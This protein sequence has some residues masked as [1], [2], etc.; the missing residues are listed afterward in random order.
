MKIQSITNYAN[1]ANYQNLKQQNSSKVSQS[2]VFKDYA[3]VYSKGIS[4]LYFGS[5]VP[6]RT[7][8]AKE[9]AEQPKVLANIINKFFKSEGTISGI[10]INWSKQDLKKAKAINI[11][12]SGSSKNAGEM[13]RSFIE[14]VADIPVNIMSASEFITSK[15]KL[16]KNDIMVFI[17][18][19][20]NTA[21]TLNALKY[22]KQQGLKTIAVTN[23]S[24][25][26]IHKAADVSLD[27][28]AGVENAVAATK[29][30][31]SSIV[32][33]WGIGMKIGEIKGSFNP[34]LA[35]S[36]AYIDA[37]KKLPA[38]ISSML[39]SSESVNR[40]ADKVAER[41]N[42]YFLAKEPNLGAVNEGALKLTETTQK[43]I[44]PGSSGEFMHGLFTSMKP[45]DVYLQIATGKKE[46]SAYNLALENFVEI[47]K[48]RNIKTPVLMKNQTNKE[49]EHIIKDADFINIPDTREEFSPLLSTIRFQQLT[50][51]ITKKLGINPDNG[52][53]VLTKYRENLSM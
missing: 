45:D 6:I 35:K 12:A 10:D 52:G 33:L 2:E 19:S 32:N 17:S 44:I 1:Y 5:V 29:T 39:K 47:V 34:I 53:G 28:E 8:F 15:P 7:S 38:Q 37:M 18:Q 26:K 22:S 23:N 24:D 14:K 25:S 49:V 11:V 41:E 9:I 42:F 50:E 51:R 30:V 40:L 27:M 4:P 31:T 13:A 46:S 16:N 36:L 3:S 43:R 21:D 20:G 48:K